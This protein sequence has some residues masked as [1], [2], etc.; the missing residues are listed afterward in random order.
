MISEKKQEQ[1]RQLFEEGYNKS[2]IARKVNVDRKTVNLC[3][4]K[5]HTT[6][7]K[8]DRKDIKKNTEPPQIQKDA[9]TV[10]PPYSKEVLEKA[11]EF[12]EKEKKEEIIDDYWRNI[13]HPLIDEGELFTKEGHEDKIKELK[14]SHNSEISELKTSY[15]SEI[16]QVKR[17]KQD[18]GN[19]IRK[20][21]GDNEALWE[22]KGSLSDYIGNY[23]DDA[24][25]RETR[26]L[27]QVRESL[28]TE[29]TNFNIDKEKENKTLKKLALDN[30]NELKK[31]EKQKEAVEKKEK[32]VEKEETQLNKLRDELR[33][34]IEGKAADLEE[35]EQQITLERN[36]LE[37]DKE[38][39][40]A[41]VAKK[42]DELCGKYAREQC[43][44][45]AE[46]K[47]KIIVDLKGEIACLK[48]ELI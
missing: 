17:E 10:Q 45:I 1:I 46:N 39:F 5:Q 4:D 20:L 3:L 2:E 37:K 19:K 6:Q 7:E 23:L 18:L 31:I 33:D 30:Y 47:N 40:K 14:K 11:K 24:G 25:R 12:I 21:C 38:N 9:V 35:K 8:S 15:D 41:D 16:S 36:L 48:R 32:E 22:T 34:E 27:E 29:K 44:K 28:A 42:K 13:L 26:R 43:Q